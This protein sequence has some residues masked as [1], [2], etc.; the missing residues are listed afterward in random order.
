MTV[1]AEQVVC[2]AGVASLFTVPA[3]IRYVKCFA[4][5]AATE[6]RKAA[7]TAGFPLPVTSATALEIGDVQG[8]KTISSSFSDLGAAELYFFNAAD[9][10]VY[11][12]YIKP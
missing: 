3:G 11:V 2:A 1:Y 10:I 8:V 5:I 6:L 12:M 9:A 4:N 7:G